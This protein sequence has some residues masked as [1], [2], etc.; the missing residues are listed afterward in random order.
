MLIFSSEFVRE[1]TR[2]KLTAMTDIKQ[3]LSAFER[4]AYGQS[5]HSAF[6]N[7]L[8]WALLP[9]KKYDS[10]LEQDQALDI[11]RNHLKVTEL[12]S[13]ITMIGD[14]SEGFSDPLGELYMQAIS[15][16]HNGQYFTPEPLCDMMATMN[17]GDKSTDAQT[18]LDCACGSGR[19]LLSAAKINRHLLLYGAD[20]DIT[21]CKMALL[22]ML[23]N[24][25]TGEITQMNSLS[26]EFYRGYKVG[27]T[28][29]NGFHMPFFTDFT[30]PQLSR[31]WLKTI[32]AK[33][34]FNT[35]FEPVRVSQSNGGIQGSLF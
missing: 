26:N 2:I 31:I 33:P 22:N 8:D 12:A 4:Y 14:L 17:I 18:V 6:T 1:F 27:T 23:L 15:Y 11:Y 3:L 10:I 19:M 25:L 29:I 24:S 32:E 7:L 30:E 21:C 28:L 34:A 35:P 16:G 13:L 5:L 9:F 20:I